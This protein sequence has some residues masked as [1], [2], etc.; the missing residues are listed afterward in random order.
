MNNNK[1]ID[2]ISWVFLA[3]TLVLLKI[4]SNYIEN[5]ID[6]KKFVFEYAL[7]GIALASLFIFLL[8][9]FKNEYFEEN[10]TRKKTILGQF[11]TIV[12]LTIF[13]STYINLKSGRTNL[14]IKRGY[15]LEKSKNIMYHDCYAFILFKNCTKE[16][17]VPTLKEWNNL[18]EK[19]SITLTVGKG[20]LGYECI[21]KFE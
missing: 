17:F 20:A 7:V 12:F 3:I 6:G 11:F 16:R 13:I 5:I 18:K 15:L 10:D 21:Y 1:I 4:K 8:Y 14:Y 9:K 2:Y 19:D